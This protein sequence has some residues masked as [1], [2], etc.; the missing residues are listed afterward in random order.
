MIYNM[1][2]MNLLRKAAEDVANEPLP[3]GSMGFEA[4]QRDAMRRL[5]STLELAKE[6]AGELAVD[7]NETENLSTLAQIGKLIEQCPNGWSEKSFEVKEIL[8]DFLGA[9]QQQQSMRDDIDTSE[10][11]KDVA[12]TML[13]LGLREGT[14]KAKVEGVA[15]LGTDGVDAL[16]DMLQNNSVGY[17]SR[18]VILEY[19]REHPEQINDTNEVLEGLA[20]MTAD[21]EGFD[22]VRAAAVRASRSLLLDDP[23]LLESIEGQKAVDGM[24][25]AT[26]GR[27][28]DRN[29][30]GP[31][32]DNSDSMRALEDLDVQE[33][34]VEAAVQALKDPESASAGRTALVYLRKTLA[35]EELV[36]FLADGLSAYGH[37]RATY[38]EI[39]RALLEIDPVAAREAAQN[40]LDRHESLL[41]PGGWLDWMRDRIAPSG[42]SYGRKEAAETIL[43]A[44]L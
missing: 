1:I 9:L 37:Y 15:K 18:G 35:R 16:E 33:Q 4:E 14:F 28:Q 26:F 23:S 19:L 8:K 2:M 24:I 5:D 36:P 27:W 7:R 31:S 17:S 10:L 38:S 12:A 6:M 22:R 29:G 42:H 11:R 32:Y 20:S 43:A 21:V 41:S 13:A 40:A 3:S 34:A 39:G 44:E 25:S 30:Y